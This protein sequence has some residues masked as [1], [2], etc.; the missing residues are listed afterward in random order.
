MNMTE[1]TSV[2]LAC[3]G[4]AAEMVRVRFVD[5]LDGM[6]EGPTLILSLFGISNMGFLDDMVASFVVVV[7]MVVAVV[8]DF[9]RLTVVRLV[10]VG[11]SGALVDAGF[12][13]DVVALLVG[14]EGVFVGSVV[15]GGVVVGSV[16][17]CSVVVG[18]VGVGSVGVILKLWQVW[19]QV[20]A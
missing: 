4:E 3:W 2:G 15:V 19:Q 9:G 6:T 14:S 16:A 17:F 18:S 12:S 11:C 1:K 20:L 7:V 5:V 13:V 10:V 8:V